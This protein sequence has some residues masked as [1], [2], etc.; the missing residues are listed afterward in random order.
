M[1]YARIYSAIIKN[2][3][4]RELPKS[5][6]CERH[7]IVPRCLGGLDEDSNLVDLTAKEHFICHL[8]LVK[9]YKDASNFGKV[10][11]AF[12]CMLWHHN[13]ETQKRYKV[14]ANRYASLRKQFSET[15]SITMR[16]EKNSNYGSFWIT[17]PKTSETKKVRNMIDGWI[18]GRNVEVCMCR[19]CGSE[20]LS[21]RS[22]SNAR[23]NCRSCI[24]LKKSKPKKI[25]P[26]TSKRKRTLPSECSCEMCHALFLS[27]RSV[28]T[29]S[30][31]CAK[32]LS[33]K[34]SKEKIMVSIIDDLGNVFQT[35]TEAS[36]FY[37][38]TVEAIRCR[39]KSGKYRKIEGGVD[40]LEVKRL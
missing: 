25:K 13:D 16:G 34:K 22:K 3:S 4:N 9:I 2:A 38:V 31:E 24:D 29:C 6:Y 1:N 26:T 10:L 12:M 5:V 21:S 11:Y 32:L 17:N 39:V 33:A 14:N 23:I 28:K 8:L 18:L 7:H 27:K 36:K 15:Q 20:M 37:N 40:T 35:L 19:N 30:S